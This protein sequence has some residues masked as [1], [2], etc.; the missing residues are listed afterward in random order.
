MLREAMVDEDGHGSHCIRIV[1][2]EP[3]CGLLGATRIDGGR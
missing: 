1:L 3:A 2:P